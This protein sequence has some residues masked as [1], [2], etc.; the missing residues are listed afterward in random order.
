[1]PSPG[2]PTW[3]I[4][5]GLSECPCVVDLCS[6]P[7]NLPS[8]FQTLILIP[9]IQA[10]C[11]PGHSLTFYITEKLEA[12]NCTSPNPFPSTLKYVLCHHPLHNFTKSRFLPQRAYPP[13]SLS[14]TTRTGGPPVDVPSS[15]KVKTLPNPALGSLRFAY[16][17]YT[18]SVLWL[19]SSTA[20]VSPRVNT[21]LLK[22]FS[23][24]RCLS[25]H[26]L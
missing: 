16:L 11:P 8:H 3:H 26:C 14:Y 5:L 9:L 25:W 12:P 19:L 24:Q 15:L 17:G 13:R 22:L 21:L 10:L 20:S 2:P 6:C 4:V 23:L 1:M 18:P 7:Q